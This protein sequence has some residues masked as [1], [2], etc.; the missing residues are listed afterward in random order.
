MKKVHDPE[1]FSD[2][3]HNPRGL[4]YGVANVVANA[5]VGEQRIVLEEI[6][7]RSSLRWYFRPIVTV[8]DNLPRRRSVES[9]DASK[10]RGLAG[11]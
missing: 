9:R 8:T 1:F 10:N 3:V 6:T 4:L 2:L 5:E 11:A 7:D